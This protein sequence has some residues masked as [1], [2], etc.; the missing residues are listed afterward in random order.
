MLVKWIL[1]PGEATKSQETA[2]V[3]IFHYLS[4]TSNI[5]LLT[6]FPSPAHR[7][8]FIYVWKEISSH[9]CFI[10]FL[11]FCWKYN[12]WTFLVNFHFTRLCLGMT[13]TRFNSA[14]RNCVRNGIRAKVRAYSPRSKSFG[15]ESSN[16]LI[17]LLGYS[18]RMHSYS[19]R[20]IPWKSKVW[21]QNFS[22]A[23]HYS[24]T[25]CPV[26]N[27]MSEHSLQEK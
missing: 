16:A 24:V 23:K 11:C 17:Y 5:A 8:T 10:N 18:S 13:N 2:S 9:P 4:N 1:F 14:L 3:F 26:G 7:H 21:R 6:W 19:N 25:F 15:V 20:P 27:P 22:A 12:A